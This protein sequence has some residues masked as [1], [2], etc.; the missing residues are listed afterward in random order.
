VQSEL[1]THEYVRTIKVPNGKGKS[2][3]HVI[4]QLVVELKAGTT[5]MLDRSGSN[6]ESS[7]TAEPHTEEEQH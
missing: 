2:A 5:R 4:Q 1:D 6:C 7:D 3:E